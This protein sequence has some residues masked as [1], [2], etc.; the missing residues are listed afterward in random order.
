[1]PSLQPRG[2]MVSKDF[3]CTLARCL[4]IGFEASFAQIVLAALEWLS[5]VTKKDQIRPIPPLDF[6]G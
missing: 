6:H 3:F 1:M 4:Y 5:S 2:S